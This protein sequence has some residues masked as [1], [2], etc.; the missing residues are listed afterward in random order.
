MSLVKVENLAA[1]Y[2]MVEVLRN[3]SLEISTGEVVAVLG[4]N[5]VGKTTLNNCLS[6]LIK[7]K[8]GKIFFEDN[9]IFLFSIEFSKFSFES[10]ISSLVFPAIAET[11]AITWLP[12]DRSFLIMLATCWILSIEPTDVPPNFNTFL[13]IFRI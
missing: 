11:T 3:I 9:L 5:G 2:G 7:P 4:S 6:G 13:I 1:G 8:N 12:N 10:L